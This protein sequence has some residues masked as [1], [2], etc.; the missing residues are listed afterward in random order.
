M[1]YSICSMP[2]WINKSNLVCADKGWSLDSMIWTFHRF[3]NRTYA[4]Q[5]AV[6]FHAWDCVAGAWVMSTEGMTP[7]PIFS[8][9]GDSC[10]LPWCPAAVAW[11]PGLYRVT[12]RYQE[13]PGVPFLTF[14]SATISE[15]L[16][17]ESKAQLQSKCHVFGYPSSCS[18]LLFIPP[19]I[20]SRKDLMPVN[21]I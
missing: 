16:G 7:L 2:F 19:T 13:V 18:D 1:L 14:M 8:W 9:G 12:C 15:Q 20:L 21:K 6:C 10:V 5:Q 11:V 4:H 17:S 3:G